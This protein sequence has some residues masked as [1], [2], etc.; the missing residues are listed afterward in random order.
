[1]KVILNPTAGRGKADRS[2]ST[3][4][5]LLQDAG[6]D[7]DLAITTGAGHAR[8]LA[9]Q[10]RRSGHQRVVAVGGDGTVQEIVQGLV[11]ASG[12]AVAGTLGII[13]DRLGLTIS[14]RWWTCR[15]IRRRPSG[16]LLSGKCVV[17]T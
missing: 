9:R 16:G 4:A 12:D 8:E 11:E 10:A 3:V 6:L 5:T 13:P 17:W 15:P 14:P 2:W 1:M 7:F